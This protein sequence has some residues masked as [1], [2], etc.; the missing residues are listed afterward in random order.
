LGNSLI[1]NCPERRIRE[2]V[3]RDYPKRK[4]PNP[5][6]FIERCTYKE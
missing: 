1:S 4:T 6:M 2:K 3:I 5:S